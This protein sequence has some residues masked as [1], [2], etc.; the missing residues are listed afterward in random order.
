VALLTVFVAAV[1]VAVV[2]ATSTSS[3]I[4]HFRTS[5]AHDAN[6]TINQL[7]HLVNS[8]TK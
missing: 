5:I 1:I 2:I 7:K 8:Y 3:G 6:S 4:A